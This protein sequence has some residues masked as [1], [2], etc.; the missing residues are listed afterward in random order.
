MYPLSSGIILRLISSYFVLFLCS[1]PRALTSPISSIRFPA[2]LPRLPFVYVDV[3]TL[4]DGITLLLCYFAIGFAFFLLLLQIS[5]GNTSG[6]GQ[7]WSTDPNSGKLLC[8]LKYSRGLA[9][10]RGTVC[11]VPI[12]SNEEQ[13]STFIVQYHIFIQLQVIGREEDTSI[14]ANK[15]TCRTTADTHESIIASKRDHRAES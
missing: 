15:A 7:R 10:L 3:S 2:A 13:T 4:Y 14:K 8:F 6:G 11:Q 12:M 9:E 5:L 1:S